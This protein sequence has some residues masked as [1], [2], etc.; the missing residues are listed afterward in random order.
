MTVIVN[1]VIYHLNICIDTV[2]IAEK[3]LIWDAP[4]ANGAYG[5][6]SRAKWRKSLLSFNRDVAVKVVATRDVNRIR[7]EVSH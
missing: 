7:N 5:A 1:K 2:L 4:I 3:E 6:V